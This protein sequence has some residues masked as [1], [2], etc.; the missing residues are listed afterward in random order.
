MPTSPSPYH[1]LRFRLEASHGT[2]EFYQAPAAMTRRL[3][4]QHGFTVVAV[5]ADWPD[6]AAVDRYVRHRPDRGAEPPFDRLPTCWG[7]SIESQ[8]RRTLIR[9]A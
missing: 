3:I 6:A 5:E 9:S 7:T 1:R 8:A 2:T 4:E